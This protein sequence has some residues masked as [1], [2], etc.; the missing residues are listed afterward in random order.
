MEQEPIRTS[1]VDAKPEQG[2]IEDLQR[3][4]H[5]AHAARM[6]LEQ[7]NQ[8]LQQKTE[9]LEAQL[10][11]SGQDPLTGLLN[12]RTAD[13]RIKA[14]M[15]AIEHK[16]SGEGARKEGYSQA[17]V[18]VIDLDHFKRVNDTYGHAAGDEVLR[19]VAEVVLANIRE[20]DLGVRWGGEEFVAV[21]KGASKAGAAMKAEELRQKI[22]QLVFEA[23]GNLQ[24]TASMGV[25]ATEGRSDCTFALLFEEADKMVYTAK[26]GGRD[27]VVVT[28]A[29]DYKKVPE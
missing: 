1:S 20:E 22:G 26:K 10:E 29:E 19:R 9:R 13:K 2:T 24:V 21:L 17:G 11:E 27:Q 16:Q 25:A 4:L 5:K 14:L 8:H 12:R 18:I 6:H 28:D 7:E 23:Y 15:N 3:Q